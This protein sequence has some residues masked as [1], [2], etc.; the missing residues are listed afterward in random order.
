MPEV[1]VYL[2]YQLHP[3]VGHF[4]I[5]DGVKDEQALCRRHWQLHPRGGS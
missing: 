4:D 1:N 3:K 2:Y 5:F